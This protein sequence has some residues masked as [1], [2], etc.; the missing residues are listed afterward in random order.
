MVPAGWK[1]SRHM[2]LRRVA[3]RARP[4]GAGFV[5]A[6]LRCDDVSSCTY[7]PLAPLVPVSYAAAPVT[8]PDP[9]EIGLAEVAG[10]R[11]S[12][13]PRATR[14]GVQV[15][16][17]CAVAIDRKTVRYSAGPNGHNVKLFAAMLH[18]EAVAIAQVRALAETNETT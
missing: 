11:A 1:Q 15:T 7:T 16:G 10:V 4:E 13:S 8:S 17:R 14:L 2:V 6:V 3:S 18:D 9:V 5:D 12:G